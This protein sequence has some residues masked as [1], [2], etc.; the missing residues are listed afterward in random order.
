MSRIPRPQN[1][2]RSLGTIKVPDTN[3]VSRASVP[4]VYAAVSS[5]I[6][7]RSGDR[8]K[9]NA[10]TPAPSTADRIVL[11]PR[12][13]DATAPQRRDVPEVPNRDPAADRRDRDGHGLE[14]ERDRLGDRE[15][16]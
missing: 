7:S 2:R 16:A 14:V 6:A 1:A 5:A 15:A 3:P 8:S 10:V 12:R 11:Q 9:Q 4:T 13:R